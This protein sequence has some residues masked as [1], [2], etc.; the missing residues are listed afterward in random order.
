MGLGSSRGSTRNT[1]SKLLARSLG[2][3]CAT[4]GGEAN[5]FP[6]LK[7]C[8]AANRKRRQRRVN[9]KTSTPTEQAGS[10]ASVSF[11]QK[12]KAPKHGA[13]SDPSST[14]RFQGRSCGRVI[15]GVT[16]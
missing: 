16:L 8:S 14:V 9:T 4:T 7:M 11:A 10:R 13:C 3:V 6:F 15:S 5:L 1:A 12:Q 2:G